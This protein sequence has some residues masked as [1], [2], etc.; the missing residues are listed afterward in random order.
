MTTARTRIFTHNQN[1]CGMPPS[2]VA[3][4]E[5]ATFHIK[6]EHPKDGSTVTL[7]P[8]GG[9]DITRGRKIDYPDCLAIATP[10]LLEMWRRRNGM[11]PQHILTVLEDW[12]QEIESN[13]LF[14]RRKIVVHKIANQ[15]GLEAISSGRRRMVFALSPDRVLKVGL[16]R[17]GMDA[18]L[19][20]ANASHRLPRHLHAVVHDVAA[21]G[22]WLVQ[23]RV[24]CGADM[25]RKDAKRLR[26]DIETCGRFFF[27]MHRNNIGHRPDGTL[28]AADL[29]GL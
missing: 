19:S 18:N 28:V 9:I 8:N 3:T 26:Q 22:L 29:E 5:D 2:E 6:I 11:L 21:D 15:L 13:S 10:S 1:P 25:R 14:R 23:E 12:R 16:S 7:G 27:D 4:S 20:E 24:K 17:F